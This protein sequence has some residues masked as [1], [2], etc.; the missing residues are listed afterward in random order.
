MRERW[1]SVVKCEEVWGSLEKWAEFGQVGRSGPK[2]GKLQGKVAKC[3]KVWQSA[4]KWAEVGQSGPK[5]GKG[6][7][8]WVKWGELQG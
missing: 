3:G 8:S 4:E 7:Q 5:W 6:W 2:W 1:K